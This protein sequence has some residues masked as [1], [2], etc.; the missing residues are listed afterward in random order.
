VPAVAQRLLPNHPLAIP[1]DSQTAMT[2]KH[3]CCLPQEAQQAFQRAP[4]SV[5]V[6]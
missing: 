4:H 1:A 5:D 3:S 6:A 2:G